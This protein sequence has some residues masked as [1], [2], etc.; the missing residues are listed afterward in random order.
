MP[1]EKK[2]KRVY[3]REDYV[4][5]GRQGGKKGGR[6][7]GLK[8]GTVSRTNFWA[9]ATDEEKFSV[10]SKGG[11]VKNNSYARETGKEFVLKS[12]KIPITMLETIRE[13]DS[14]TTYS[15]FVNDNIVPYIELIETFSS[16]FCIEYVDL[17]KDGKEYRKIEKVMLGLHK[18]IVDRI[19]A[20]VG[21][22]QRAKFLLAYTQ[23]VVKLKRKA[24]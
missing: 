19:D 13:F 11:S 4:E 20:L 5:W 6:A 12:I 17:L 15:R 16:P 7:G 3:T 2:E 21:V 23:H 1:K 8:G 18:D 14:E 9:N 24:I 10:C 22:R